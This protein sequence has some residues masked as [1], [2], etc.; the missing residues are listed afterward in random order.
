MTLLQWL[1]AG[2]FMLGMGEIIALIA[3][4]C[5]AGYLLRLLFAAFFKKEENDTEFLELELEGLQEKFNVQMIQKQEEVRSLKDEVKVAEQKNFDLQVEYAKALQHIEAIKNNG[6]AID[7]S[8]LSNDIGK[9]LLDS[10]KDRITLQE[11]L[12]AQLQQQL[13]Q[14][15]QE[16]AGL[17][18]ELETNISN[19]KDHKANAEKNRYELETRLSQLSGQ[20]DAKEH[21][22]KE[23]QLKLNERDEQSKTIQ[24]QLQEE[25]IKHEHESAAEISKLKAE[26]EQ[27]QTK[28]S[29]A[30][31]SGKE[32]S[33]IDVIRTEA[34]NV[35]TVME[36]FKHYLAD[37]MRK[38]LELEQLLDKNEKLN[39]VVDQLLNEKQEQQQELTGLQQQLQT[40]QHQKDEEA[41]KDH[42]H[43]QQLKQHLHNA[44]QEWS[45]TT[46]QLKDELHQSRLRSQEMEEQKNQLSEK[47]SSLQQQSEEK[48]RFTLQMI[49]TLKEFEMRMVPANKEKQVCEAALQEERI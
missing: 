25:H 28:L 14:K 46:E 27:L 48:E 16:Y 34:G 10:L 3:A 8:L 15:E 47:L 29:I 17:S 21:L 19:F 45:T 23:Q 26:I 31:T 9:G 2:I 38:T 39:L 13:D 44:Q 36:D 11:Q 32:K 4:S 6:S 37:T 24:H 35:S 49:K 12:A 7:E 40:L 43:I 20:L 22:I 42:E 18:K 1:Y 5:I 41:A 30:H 33:T